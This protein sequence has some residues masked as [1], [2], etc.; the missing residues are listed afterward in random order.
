[1]NKKKDN[2]FV[3]NYLACWN[4]LKKAEEHVVIAFAIFCAFVIIGF[5]LPIW[6]NNEIFDLIRNMSEQFTGLSLFWTIIKIFFNNIQASF[7]AI[8]IGIGF[9]IFP[10]ITAII[11][12]YVVGFVSRYA[13]NQQGI[14]ILWKLLPHGIFE[15]PAIILSIGIG[16]K[17]GLE[18]FKPFKKMKF[19][20]NFIEA[21]RFF[22]FVVFPLLLIAAVIEGF[23]VFY[24]G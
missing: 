9:G 7:F 13:V 17:L 5:A 4:F 16:F 20:Y 21:M 3:R 11:N 23:L 2:F 1:M 24:L 18:L 15:I 22:A 6:F 10:L 14:F 8:F 19:K 12:G